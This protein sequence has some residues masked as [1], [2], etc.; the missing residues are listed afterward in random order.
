MMVLAALAAHDLSYG[1]RMAVRRE[2]PVRITV[3]H[4]SKVRHQV[5]DE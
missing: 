4:S 2:A 1:Y 5:Y 3:V